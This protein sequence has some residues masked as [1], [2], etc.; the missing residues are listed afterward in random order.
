[1]ELIDGLSQDEIDA[2]LVGVDAS[3]LGASDNALDEILDHFEKY[4]TANIT[5]EKIRAKLWYFFG[6][7]YY[8]GVSCDQKRANQWY[9][10]AAE[11]QLQE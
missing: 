3:K 5:S 7:I 6:V 2:L 9:E 10:K 1:M 11:K 4:L 8:Y